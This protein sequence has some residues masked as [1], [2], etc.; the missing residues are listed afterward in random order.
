[1]TISPKKTKI[2]IFNKS[3][4]MIRIKFRISE[5]TIESCSPYT[6]LGTVFT[7]NNNFKKALISELDKKAC[8]A[9]FGYLKEV[10]IQAGA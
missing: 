6:Y 1:M 2:I 3:G 8:Q 7:R 5:L 10:N 9:F 4:R